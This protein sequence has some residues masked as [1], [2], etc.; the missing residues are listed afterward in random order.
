M[1]FGR[2]KGLSQ[3][4]CSIGAG[5]TGFAYSGAFRTK[6]RFSVEV[7]IDTGEK[8]KNKQFFDRLYAQKEGIEKEINMTLSWE[9]LDNARACRIAVYREGSIDASEEELNELQDWAIE[10]LIKLYLVNGSKR[11]NEIEP[12]C[13]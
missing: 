1:S 5:R 7:Y 2:C 13:R 4:W 11:Y 10:T 6:A 9:R 3:S 8:E 12:L